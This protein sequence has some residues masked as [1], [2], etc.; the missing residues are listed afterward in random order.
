MKQ[1]HC[2]YGHA[3]VCDGTV[4]AD[5]RQNNDASYQE[6]ENKLEHRHLDTRAP[7]EQSDYKHE[8]EVTCNCVYCCCLRD[9]TSSRFMERRRPEWQSLEI[10]RPAMTSWRLRVLRAE[11]RIPQFLVR[12]PKR[13][14][15]SDHHSRWRCLGW[16][17]DTLFSKFFDETL[18]DVQLERTSLEN[19]RF[20]LHHKDRG[21]ARA[22]NPVVLHHH[23][24]ITD[25]RRLRPGH[26]QRPPKV[27]LEKHGNHPPHHAFELPP[28][29][30]ELQILANGYLLVDLGN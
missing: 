19:L 9:P 5:S 8:D 10:H 12:P 28:P 26:A 14:Y 30:L 1:A 2:E 18:T 29:S 11:E 17:Y 16:R 24:L 4:V 25:P 6:H 7:A 23:S 15:T 27:Q 3:A 21:S 20:Q 13:T 22:F